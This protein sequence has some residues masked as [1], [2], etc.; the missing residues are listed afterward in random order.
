M[1]IKRKTELSKQAITLLAGHDDA[2]INEVETALKQ[3]AD[4]VDSELKAARKRRAGK[5]K[6]A[7]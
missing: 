5:A 7:A 6:K 2:P 1:D 3:V 4:H